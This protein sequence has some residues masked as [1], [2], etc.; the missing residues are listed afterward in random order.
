MSSGPPCW[1]RDPGGRAA[2]N[3]GNA[4]AAAD[5]GGWAPLPALPAAAAEGAAE[6]ALPPGAWALLAPLGQAGGEGVRARE[7]LEG[8]L[9]AE[10][11][12]VDRPASYFYAPEAFPLVACD[13][14][15]LPGPEIADLARELLGA[16]VTGFVA[17]VGAHGEDAE[18]VPRALEA[19]EAVSVETGAPVVGALS[20]ALQMRRPFVETLINLRPSN[21]DE[22][23]ALVSNLPVDK[24]HRVSLVYEDDPEGKAVLTA[25]KDYQ[26]SVGNRV[27]TSGAFEP[28]A[29][30]PV[31]AADAIF[32]GEKIPETVVLYS[33]SAADLAALMKEVENR[34][35]PE[36]YEA[37]EFATFSDA[38]AEELHH[39]LAALSVSVKPGQLILSQVVPDPR[40]DVPIAG[41]YR[42]GLGNVP[43]AAVAVGAEETPFA[44]APPGQ[45]GYHVSFESF[46][47]GV[48]TS[49]VLG[50][51]S[52]KVDLWDASP[53]ALRDTF[54]RQ[55]YSD[56][57][58]DLLGDWRFG[59]FGA[60][61]NV[62]QG[63]YAGASYAGALEGT[64]CDCNQGARSVFLT[65]MGA[66]GH[67]GN[68]TMEH[69]EME[70]GEM[71]HGEM[72]HAGHAGHMGGLDTAMHQGSFALEVAAEPFAFDTC[73]Y[74]PPEVRP[75]VLGQSCALTGNARSL[76]IGVSTGLAAAFVQASETGGVRGRPIELVSLDDGYEPEPALWNSQ[77][78]L[79]DNATRLAA[80][81]G[82]NEIFSATGYRWNGEPVLFLVGEVGTPTTI[83]V[84]GRPETPERERYL[85]LG[86]PFVGAFTGAGLLR[87]PFVE[88]FVNVRASYADE[89]VVTVNHLVKDLGLDRIS[90]LHQDDGFGQAG[91][92]P[93]VETLS[94]LY[95]LPLY[96][97]GKYERNTLNV[98]PAFDAIFPAGEPGP[99]AVFCMGAYAPIAEFVKLVKETHPEVVVS[100]ISFAGA[101]ALSEALGPAY[102][103][104]VLMTQVTP[105]PRG[106]SEV[107][108][109][110][111]SALSAYDPSFPPS[112]A[113]FEGFLDGR[114][115]AM[116]LQRIPQEMEITRET[117]LDAVYTGNY[118]VA[119]DLTLGPYVEGE[120]NQGMK[121][122]WLTEFQSNGTISETGPPFRFETC[123]AAQAIAAETEADS[124]NLP[125]IIG[126]VCGGAAVL[127]LGLAGGLL[128]YF[129]RTLA[130]SQRDAIKNTWLVNYD[131]IVFEHL[132][133]EGATGFTFYGK[134]RDTPV[135]IKQVKYGRGGSKGS[136]S[137]SMSNSRSNSMSTGQNQQSSVTTSPRP[138]FFGSDRVASRNERR[139]EQLER[140]AHGKYAPR[141]REGAWD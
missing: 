58:V 52:D 132:L 115:S 59:P 123:Q 19:L 125:L 38:D 60:S 3:A 99:Q 89:I 139:R 1:V 35:G 65:F 93:L 57:V 119:E 86:V 33:R 25:M 133:G 107:A 13:I 102:R 103:Q 56:G 69:G 61:C 88:E 67:G 85:E 122:V 110:Y 73:G 70:H 106:D 87:D 44:E 121:D 112:Y 141:S 80:E 4:T 5:A 63:S 105:N 55:V 21:A 39:S 53:A 14:A 104:G 127:V 30:D 22:A 16:G 95:N 8:L 130:R 79:G 134:Y 40:A 91:F 48:F 36:G 75:I 117:F 78:L 109:M 90:I 82:G 111:R 138:G 116:A 129:R 50:E 92:G 140:E 20:G 7:A 68:S 2:G 49:T 9:A 120:C 118:Q 37:M 45:P 94:T 51:M 76:G 64:G 15:G 128:L 131:D 98:Q 114:L 43:A 137:N 74:E 136:D 97:D 96:S 126:V 41:E 6:G 77:A 31:A 46:M 66:G 23:Y 42:A 32:A 47:A 108:A 27:Y 124:L 100:V 28:G 26:R 113:S 135:I 29:F 71:D 84:V 81:E 18:G 101:E 10:R 17:P 83:A 12:V 24:S 54:L 72:H 11:A 62:T 34:L